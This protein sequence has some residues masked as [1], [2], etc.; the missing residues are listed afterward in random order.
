VRERVLGPELRLPR[1]HLHRRRLGHTTP[2]HLTHYTTAF[3]RDTPDADPDARATLAGRQP[4]LDNVEFST[5]VAVTSTNVQPPSTTV[6]DYAIVAGLTMPG[7]TEQVPAPGETYDGVYF[8]YLHESSGS[9]HLDDWA[10][11][12]C[13]HSRVPSV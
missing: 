3:L 5:S 13:R 1:R 7:A 9:D 8:A 4:D 2:R 6:V 10:M 11:T 12:S